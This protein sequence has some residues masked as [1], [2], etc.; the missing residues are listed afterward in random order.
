MHSCL[1]IGVIFTHYTCQLQRN[2]GVIKNSTSSFYEQIFP[3]IWLLCPSRLLTESFLTPSPSPQKSYISYNPFKGGRMPH[4]PLLPWKTLVPYP[5]SPLPYSDSSA[6]QVIQLFLFRVHRSHSVPLVPFLKVSTNFWY[7]AHL[8]Q[9]LLDLSN[10][11]SLF[12]SL[13]S[14]SGMPTVYADN[15][16]HILASRALF[17]SF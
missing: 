8:T 1:F 14:P 3:Q 7:F 13:P 15:A 17:L 5:C 12:S 2:Y 11:C 4:V 16:P 10:G 6:A 9:G